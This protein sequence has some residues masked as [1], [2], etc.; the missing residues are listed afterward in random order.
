MFQVE[1]AACMSDMFYVLIKN[2]Y[3]YR[4]H[5]NFRAWGSNPQPSEKQ[6]D[7]LST[8]QHRREQCCVKRW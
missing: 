7:S 8:A 1:I 5:E 3:V 4:K 2:E 6:P